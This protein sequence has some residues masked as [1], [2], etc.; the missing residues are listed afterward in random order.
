MFNL[1]FEI[2][3][4]KLH[5]WILLGA[6]P[7]LMFCIIPVQGM[8]FR[9]SW[10][11]ASIWLGGLAFC[12]FLSSWWL[13]AFLL[14][15]LIRTATLVPGI[16]MY[17]SLMMVVIFLAAIEGFKRIDERKILACI[18]IAAGFLLIWIYVQKLGFNFPK[19]DFSG[20]FNPDAAGVFL[21]LTLPAFFFKKQW[22]AIPFIFIGL[23][24]IGTS[25][26]FIAAI[27]ASIISGCLCKELKTKVK[28]ASI[29]II[30]IIA[31][32]WFWKVDPS[33]NI[34]KDI[35]WTIWKHAAWS[36]RSEMLGRG[37]GSWKIQFPFLA[38]GE[39]SLG[40]VTNENGKITL[41]GSMK[42]AHNEY[43]QT[44]FELG[45]QAVLLIGLFLLSA[46]ITI[47]A[48]NVSPHA[49]GGL[50]ALAVSCFGWHVF[51]IAPLALLGCAWLG[52]W[53]KGERLRAKGE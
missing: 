22:Y 31:G 21:A 50:V 33:V 32:L 26:G 29:V 45:S 41:S 24:V 20:P 27:A 11:L 2:Q 47:C 36:M 3:H 7:G 34:T 53:M 12:A 46:A 23:A 1:K 30:C 35:R 8:A 19:D 40:I 5:E 25:T 16:D 37:L 38:S 14:L 51:H 4:S 13:R 49:A 43:A 9:F 48:G 17:I 28:I 52:I 18:K 39:K 15:A 10:Q 42:Q 44:G 6:I